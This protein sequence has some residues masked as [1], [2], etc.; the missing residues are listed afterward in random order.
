MVYKAS[1]TIGRSSFRIAQYISIECWWSGRDSVMWWEYGVLSVHRGSHQ[2]VNFVNISSS[3]SWSAQLIGLH[4]WYDID[5]FI[6]CVPDKRI[7][8]CAIYHYDNFVRIYDKLHHQLFFLWNYY[9][10]TPD[11]IIY[12]PFCSLYHQSATVLSYKGH[13]CKQPIHMHHTWCIP[14]MVGV[15]YYSRKGG[16]N[17]CGWK[18]QL[19]QELQGY[20]RDFRGNWAIIQAWCEV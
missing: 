11:V 9:F 5:F 4:P 12:M 18:H 15:V 2:M 13:Q 17:D 7:Y 8:P 16:Y 20:L 10:L 6:F 14:T 3:F 1:K 19:W